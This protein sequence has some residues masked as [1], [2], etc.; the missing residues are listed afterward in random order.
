MSSTFR[1]RG[2]SLRGRA[3]CVVFFA[4]VC[5]CCVCGCSLTHPQAWIQPKDYLYNKELSATYDQTRIKKSLTLDVLPRIGQ[6]KDEL[7]SQSDSVVASLGQGKEGYKTW[8][9]MVAFHEYELSVIRKYF[10][11]VDEKVE[12]RFTLGRGLRF[13]CEMLLD[14][15]ELEKL[16]D[17]K[18]LG[19]VALLKRI[20]ENLGRDACEL[21][22]GT[23]A[24]RSAEGRLDVNVLL[25]KQVL[26]TIVRGLERSPELAARISD[27]NGIGFDHINF[28]EGKVR[29]WAEGNVVA[30]KIRLGAFLP[31]FQELAGP[32]VAE[33]AQQ[34]AKVE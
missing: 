12:K 5:F 30:V 34:A 14:K 18:E 9:T 15:E 22:G 4:A 29:M 24:P 21:G 19:E 6:L 1:V 25:I 17:A 31:T 3:C 8:F 27:A 23:E 28:G 2:A 16:G 32:A 7:L 10:F 20:G 26:D 11:V 33:P 13:D